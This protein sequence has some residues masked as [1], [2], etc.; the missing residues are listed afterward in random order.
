M[1]SLAEA[2]PMEARL[3]STAYSVFTSAAGQYGPATLPL[4][5]QMLTA[6]WL[7]Q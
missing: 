1:E 4:V 7:V 5:V 3:K 6:L 2:P